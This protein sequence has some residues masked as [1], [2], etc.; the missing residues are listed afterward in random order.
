M[1]I[2]NNLLDSAEGTQIFFTH[3]KLG[4]TVFFFL[5]PD[6]KIIWQ[7]YNFQTGRWYRDLQQRRIRELS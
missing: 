1:I 4:M 6:I 7:R 2:N 5:I 3:R